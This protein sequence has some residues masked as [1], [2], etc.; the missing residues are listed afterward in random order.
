MLIPS[1]DLMGGK[2]VQL[3]QG[4]KKAL[5]FDN[6]DEWIE[7]FRPY[8]I[9]QLIDLDAAMRQGSN[10]ELIGYICERI[11]C[12][13]G[14]GIRTPKDALELLRTGAKKVI[15]GSSLLREGRVDLDAAKAEDVRGC[16][17]HSAF[18]AYG[19]SIPG[20]PRE[21][22]DL[23]ALIAERVG[24]DVDV[25]PE[26]VGERFAGASELER[27]FFGGNPSERPVRHA[28]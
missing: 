9:V 11:P 14:G 2:V 3:V 12:Q 8:P 15:I 24:E 1:I 26:Q 25:S 22:A 13:V 19:A 10:R 16:D 4:A 28:V 5:E 18:A 21:R 7:R 17:V 6:V 23:G 20:V 27:G